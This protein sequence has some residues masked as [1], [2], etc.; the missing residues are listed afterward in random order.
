MKIIERTY[1]TVVPGKMDEMQRLIDRQ[2]VICKGMP[3]PQSFRAYRSLSSVDNFNTVVLEFD[4][5][6]FGDIGVLLEKQKKSKE[7]QELLNEVITLCSTSIH[8][9]YT[10]ESWGII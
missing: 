7:Y 4:W 6:N 8:E 2:F 5:D 9:F 3:Q 10:P 1:I